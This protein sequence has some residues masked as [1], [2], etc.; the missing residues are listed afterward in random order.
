MGASPLLRTHQLTIVADSDGRLGLRFC[1]K[2]RIMSMQ[3][4]FNESLEHEVHEEEDGQLL[5]SMT[6]FNRRG[7]DE[8]M[9]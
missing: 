8:I 7:C 4:S 9:C 2:E 1:R 3:E 6:S 5:D